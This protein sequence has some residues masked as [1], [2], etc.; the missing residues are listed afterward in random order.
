[1]SKFEGTILSKRCMEIV[2]ELNFDQLV[3]TNKLPVGILNLIKI[4]DNLKPYLERNL[5]NN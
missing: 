5:V 2:M 4:F 3:D 1:M